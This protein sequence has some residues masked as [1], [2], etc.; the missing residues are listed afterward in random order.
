MG[1]FGIQCPYYE[2]TKNFE[3]VFHGEERKSGSFKRLNFDVLKCGDCGG[4]RTHAD[5]WYSLEVGIAAFGIRHL[6]SHDSAEYAFDG[7]FDTGL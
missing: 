6:G 3:R 5:A 7:N 1:V 2:E 4:L